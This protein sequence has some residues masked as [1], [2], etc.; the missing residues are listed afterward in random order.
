MNLRGYYPGSFSIKTKNFPVQPILQMVTNDHQFNLVDFN[1]NAEGT[2]HRYYPYT[3]NQLRGKMTIDIKQGKL[4]PTGHAIQLHPFQLKLDASGLIQLS[5]TS[6]DSS[7]GRIS[8]RGQF[9]FTNRDPQR[10]KKWRDRLGLTTPELNDLPFYELEFR[11]QSQLYQF[12]KDLWHCP[13]QEGT[14]FYLRGVGQFS[15]CFDF[16]E[17][18]TWF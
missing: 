15:K 8:F 11:G 17:S 4:H 5:P 18:R 1:F 14:S 2:F 12:A 9:G 13:Q 3:G 6:A 7:L 16:K 10:D